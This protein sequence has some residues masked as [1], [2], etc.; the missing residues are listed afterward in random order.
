M[1]IALTPFEAL[2]GFRPLNEIAQHM[3]TYY[4]LSELIG[5]NIADE[6]IETVKSTSDSAK[7][8]DIE[9]NKTVLKKIFSALMH[10]SQEKVTHCLAKLIARLNETKANDTISKLL[11]RLDQQYP[12]GDVGVFSSLMLNYVSMEPGQAI[13]LGANEPHAYLSGGKKKKKID[14]RDR[15]TDNS[16]II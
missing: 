15:Y 14:G 9:Q 10:S 8:E 6:F 5:K 11:I 16:E 13:F 2:C 7:T 1:A 4:E 3:E 12:G